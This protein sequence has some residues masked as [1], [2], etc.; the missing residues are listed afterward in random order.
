[1]AA[2]DVGHARAALEFFF[3]AFE[4]GNPRRREVCDIAR[5]EKALG[6]AEELRAVLV[7]AD[8]GARLERVA[9][10]RLVEHHRA[11]DDSNAPATNT[12]LPSCASAMACSGGSVNVSVAAS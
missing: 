11:D 8:A 12:G 10:D 5:T 7:P 6:A 2:A 4:R 1:M 3:D 9:D